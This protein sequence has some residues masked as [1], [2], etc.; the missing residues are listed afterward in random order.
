MAN[1]KNVIKLIICGCP[2]VKEIDASNNRLTVLEISELTNLEYLHVGNNQLR[3]L[4]LEQNT[5]LKSLIC[6]NNPRL[7]KENIKGL[8]KLIRLKFIDCDERLQ[9]IANLKEAYETKTEEIQAEKDEALRNLQSEQT[10]HG[11]TLARLISANDTITDAQNELGVTNLNNLPL[12]PEGE[13]L[14]TLLQ[15]P[16]QEELK[17]IGEELNIEREHSR[18]ID[19]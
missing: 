19:R 9:P 15:R 2:L 8:E 13:T 6:F 17:Q 10:A 16:T 11:E 14:H 7:R 18:D 5:K 12:M 4:D 3:E 1:N